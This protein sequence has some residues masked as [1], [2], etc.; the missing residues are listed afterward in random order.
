MDKKT[1]FWRHYTQGFMNKLV[2]IVATVFILV[3]ISAFIF[4]DSFMVQ[5]FTG[6]ITGIL[7][8]TIVHLV[9]LAMSYKTWKDTL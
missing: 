1:T 4:G 7:G 8:G 2:L 5:P 9:N 6:G 3:G